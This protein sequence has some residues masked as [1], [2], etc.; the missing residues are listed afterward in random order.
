MTSVATT[1]G[2]G[3]N[4][5]A[6]PVRIG[7]ESWEASRAPIQPTDVVALFVQLAKGAG[8]LVV[9]SATRIRDPWITSE[10]TR[11]TTNGQMSHHQNLI[12]SLG[13]SVQEA[14]EI[15]LR[16]LPFEDD[17]NAPGMEIYDAL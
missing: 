1:F 15:R 16:L 2:A 5:F 6:L 7:E 14:A 9:S 8:T 3:V 4:G 13:W 12:S 10:H 11:T 17:W